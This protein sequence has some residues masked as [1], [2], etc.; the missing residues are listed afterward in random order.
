MTNSPQAQTPYGW[1]DERTLVLVQEEDLFLLA[2]DADG[3][4][5]PLLESGAREERPSVSP[6]RRWI[7][8]ESDES[9]QREIYVRPLADPAGGQ[10]LVSVGGGSADDEPLWSPTGREIFYR[11][12]TQMMRVPVNAESSFDSGNPEAVFQTTGYGGGRN[13]R[14]DVSPD[15]RRILI[16]RFGTDELVVVLNWLEELKRLVPVD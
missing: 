5:T 6:D 16:P 11:T 10:W 13:R 14:F 3:T 9:G 12:G 2:L 1:A 4:A 8:Y 15:G 7:A